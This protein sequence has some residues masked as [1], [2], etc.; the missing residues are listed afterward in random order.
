MRLMRDA[1]LEL[2][3]VEMLSEGTR[4]MKERFEDSHHWETLVVSMEG[5]R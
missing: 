1:G 3:G 4:A 2:V 5:G